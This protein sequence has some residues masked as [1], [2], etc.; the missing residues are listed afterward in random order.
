MSVLGPHVFDGGSADPVGGRGWGPVAD[1]AA[2]I[3]GVQRR[4]SDW[5]GPAARSDRAKRRRMPAELV[6]PVEGWALRRP[7]PR[8]AEVHREG[9]LVALGV[10]GEQF[11]AVAV[12]A[13]PTNTDPPPCR[14]TRNR[15]N[16]AICRYRSLQGSSPG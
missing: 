5:P 7:P 3:V 1:R 10:A 13:L 14:R 4:G 12:R 8:I 9:V 6:P 16:F 15:G 2:V 11:P